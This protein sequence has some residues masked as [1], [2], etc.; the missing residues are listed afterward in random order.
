MGRAPILGARNEFLACRYL[1]ERG[2][3]APRVAAFAERG[4]N[5]AR[6]RSFVLCDELAGYTSLE[7]LTAAWPSSP[8]DPLHVRRLVEAVAAFSRELHAAGIVHRDYYI[9]HLWLRDDAWQ[10]GRAE[11]AVIDLHRALRFSQLP[12]RWRKRDLAAL[13]FSVLDL[14][15][16]QRTWLRFVRHYRGKPLKEIFAQEGDFWR[17]VYARASALY[18]KGEKKGLTQGRFQPD[19]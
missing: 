14:P 8:P 19:V 6:R 9:C 17:A 10:Q 18:R 4:W 12:D 7:D 2:V 5:P 13:L 11:L 16:H 15:V 3:I 1:E